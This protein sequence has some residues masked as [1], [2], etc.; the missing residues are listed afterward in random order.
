MDR[1]NLARTGDYPGGGPTREPHVLWKFKAGANV[2]STPAVAEGIV[3]VGSDDHYLYALDAQSGALMW[4]FQTGDIVQSGPAVSEGTVYV[5]S[6]DSYLYALDAKNGHLKWKF[7]R[8]ETIYSSPAI[9]D[10]VVY[11]GS[12][13][14]YLYA[15]ESA[16]GT[17]RWKF[18]TQGVVFS[19]PAVD[20]GTVYFGSGGADSNLYALDAATGQER[21][22]LKA[23]GEVID[24]PAVFEGAV[25]VTARDGPLYAVNAKTGGQNW[26]VPRL[27]GPP[28]IAAGLVL[29]TDWVEDSGSFYGE[30]PRVVALDLRDGRERWTFALKGDEAISRQS[31]S[32]GNLYFGRSGPQRP[33]EGP[34][35][36][37]S[38]YA[39]DLQTGR[40]KW[41]WQMDVPD[42][43]ASVALSQGV[44]YFGGGEY[45]YAVK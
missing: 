37:G 42:G 24:A 36:S 3:Y 33:G 28:T 26:T 44:A 45:L 12:A 20:G 34:T 23:A 38:L 2:A 9:A 27:R 35:G 4:K 25:Y 41:Q 11:F 22:K 19:S 5:G 40:E 17:E 6:A 16:S 39:L 29:G 32:N 15:V 8:A 18:E 13:D 31:A 21:W 10:G 30:A 1:A 7:Q 43:P 14:H